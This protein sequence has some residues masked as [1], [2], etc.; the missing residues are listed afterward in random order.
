MTRNKIHNPQLTSSTPICIRHFNSGPNIRQQ[1]SDL[2]CE[3]I[4]DGGDMHIK[5]SFSCSRFDYVQ[6]QKASR[7]DYSFTQKN[8][9]YQSHED[10]H[11][12]QVLAH[13]QDVKPHSISEIPDQDIS[14]SSF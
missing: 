9:R 6:F 5:L 3:G 14:V 1:F 8:V 4:P 12:N 13:M 2:G 10:S 11:N 7:M